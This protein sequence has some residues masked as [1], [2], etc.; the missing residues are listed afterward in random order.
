MDRGD[1]KIVGICV[2]DEPNRATHY[3]LY[4]VGL[5]ILAVAVDQ[6]VL[7]NR[8]WIDYRIFTLPLIR[9]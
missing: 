2:P 6:V 8:H 1:N 4:A 9:S 5:T 3:I 7:N